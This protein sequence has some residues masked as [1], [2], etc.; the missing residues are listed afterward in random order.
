LGHG[1]GRRT[2]RAA[3][4]R[5]ALASSVLLGR[6]RETRSL[7]GKIRPLGSLR[8]A[9][10]GSSVAVVRGLGDGKELVEACFA[11]VSAKPTASPP[12]G[13]KVATDGPPFRKPS[14]RWLG[15][16]FDVSDFG[17]V[18]DVPPEL[19]AQR[20]GDVGVFVRD[21]VDSVFFSVEVVPTSELDEGIRAYITNREDVEKG[22]AVEARSRALDT[23]LGPAHE[24]RWTIGPVRVRTIAIPI[25]G[26]L[27]SVFVTSSFVGQFGDARYEQLLGSLHRVGSD[28]PPACL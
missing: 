5:L 23:S 22:K 4:R 21:P 17:F 9:R 25:C 27:R 19:S 24:R 11:A 28:A 12:L 7:D 2:S 15:R 3:L 13:P 10:K 26:A 14:A 8:I 18:F 16:R 20:L 6:G 1:V